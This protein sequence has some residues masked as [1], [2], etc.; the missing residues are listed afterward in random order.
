MSENYA[1]RKLTMDYD[2]QDVRQR[3]LKLYAGLVYDAMEYL[4]TG[5][6]AMAGGIYPLLYTMKVAGPATMVGRCQIT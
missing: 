1:I 4:G 2:V 3:Y 5:G 6:Q